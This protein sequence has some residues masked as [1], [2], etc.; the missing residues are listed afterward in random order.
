M[1][2][3]KKAIILGASSGIGKEMALIL[4][5]ENWQVAITGRRQALLDEIAAVH[6]GTIFPS[7][8][9]VDDIEALPSRLD[10]LTARFSGLDLLVISAG[11]GYLNANL[12]LGPE[13]QTVRTN[14]AAFTVAASWALNYFKKQ[15]H[16]H[17]AAITSVGG[18]FGESEAPAYPAS[19]AYQILYLD[20]LRKR[21]NKEKIN[22]IVT[23]LRPGSVKT[24]MMKGDGHFWISSPQ[25]AAKLACTAIHRKKRLQYISR[26]W[27]LIGYLLRCFALFK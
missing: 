15:G 23:E 2:N 9:D 17:L 26:R 25:S 16:G 12:S 19:K 18:L 21:I 24:D 5:K 6:S 3:H 13:L 4:A 1:G 27:L 20:S 7:V 22:C 11:C 14:V 8:L 10:D